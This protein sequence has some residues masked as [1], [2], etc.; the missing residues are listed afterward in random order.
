MRASVIMSVYNGER[1]QVLEAVAS[2]LS[3]EFQDFELVLCDDG[4]G[5]E[6]AEFLTDLAA[7]N[8]RV[9]LLRN[10]K[11]RGL[12]FSL[13]R[14]IGKAKGPILIRQDGDD[15][16]LPG[17]L[18][19]LTA[20]L[21][22]HP[23]Y[24]MVSSNVQLFDSR[25]TWGLMRYPE[26]PEPRDFLF[27][28]PFCHGACAMRKEAVE[29]A[30]CYL[31]SPRT[32]RCEDLELFLQ[33]YLRGSRGYT[34]PEALYA[35]R[36]DKNARQRRKYRHRV[37]EA[38]V[39]LEGYRN[40]GLLPEGFLWAAKPLAVG[41]LPPRMLEALKDWHYHRRLPEKGGEGE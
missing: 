21:E 1:G 23:Q 34:L 25:G 37:E 7:R 17:R 12:A 15:R 33:M 3:Q 10:R 14:C 22:T 8:H 28:L 27:A 29:A 18:E 40:L 38:L 24:D 32:R 4:S 26:T 20:F 31:D 41:L 36:E 2:I 5:P 39:R 6:M 13:N 35:Y 11:N 19:A 9:R 16:S 30:G